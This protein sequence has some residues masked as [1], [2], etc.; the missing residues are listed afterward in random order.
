RTRGLTDGLST[1]EKHARGT[2]GLRGG[3]SRQREVRTICASA[4]ERERRMGPEESHACLGVG[5]GQAMPQVSCR[6]RNAL[7]EERGETWITG[8][9]RLEE[10]AASVAHTQRSLLEGEKT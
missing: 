3:W 9:K 2:D 6:G 4:R 10:S 7:H 5:E 8:K 1:N